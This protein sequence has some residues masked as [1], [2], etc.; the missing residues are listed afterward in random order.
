M[1]EGLLR[2]ERIDLSGADLR[3]ADLSGADLSRADLRG[4]TSAGPASAG[5]IS[6]GPTS[7][8]P[9]LAGPTSVRDLAPM[10]LRLLNNTKLKSRLPYPRKT[11]TI[12][13]LNSCK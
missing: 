7:G 11:L 13:I 5:P 6:A 3:E 12:L 10:L 9:T 8:G 4:P 2:G 1:T